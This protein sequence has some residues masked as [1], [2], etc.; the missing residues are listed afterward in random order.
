ME[1]VDIVLLR[2]WQMSV[3]HHLAALGLK[4]YEV[5]S[6]AMAVPAHRHE[7]AYFCMLL[8]GDFENDYGSALLPFDTSLNVFHPAGTVHTS[9]VGARGA[10]LLTVET[11]SDWI[12]RAEAHGR[13]PA[14]PAPLARAES[15]A[16]RQLLRE[17]RQAQPCSL[18][19]IEG[20]VLELLAGVLR[21]PRAPCDSPVWLERARELLHGEYA[22]PW[23]LADL[24]ARLGAEPT[25]L[26]TAFRRRFG[27]GVGD[28]LRGLRVR[29]VKEALPGDAALA[30]I[31]L[32]AGFADQAHCT[33][34]FKRFTGTTPG[35]AR[36]ALRRHGKSALEEAVD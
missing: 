19:A 14:G 15:R 22:Q 18:L 4:L 27:H 12:A 26:S 23:T 32:S 28:Y 1:S 29:H 2:R 25:R 13:V 5:K 8:D 16:G 6:G 17:L 35:Q 21:A 9:I 3:P 11:T 10:H 34:V 31:A 30:D 24:A 33:R 7:T 36:R 20:L